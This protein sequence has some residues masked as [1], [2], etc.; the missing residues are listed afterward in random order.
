M[1]KKSSSKKNNS[2][3]DIIKNITT[4]RNKLNE[5]NIKENFWVICDRADFKPLTKIIIKEDDEDEIEIKTIIHSIK[6]IRDHILDE[7]GEYYKGKKMANL[8]VTFNNDII[9]KITKLKYKG[10]IN[11]SI[12]NHVDFKNLKNKT[13]VTVTINIYVVNDD[14][15]INTNG[16]DCWGLKVNY[17]ID[18]FS[19]IK[20]KL[21]SV[22]V[23]MRLVSDCIVKSD[24]INGITYKNLSTQLNKKKK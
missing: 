7:K 18:D 4:F 17:H 15:D 10:V 12:L 2:I 20:F 5:K 23:L 21:K 8:K 16:P 19:T 13:I 1:S 11:N 24:L 6:E 9:N 22:E 3:K 14:G